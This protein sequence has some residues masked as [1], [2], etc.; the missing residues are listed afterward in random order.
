[1][2]ETASGKPPRIRTSSSQPMFGTRSTTRRNGRSSGAWAAQAVV[3]W[4]KSTWGGRTQLMR[5]MRSP[6]SAPVS[7]GSG[8]RTRDR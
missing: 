2:T 1:M 7:G 5:L 8:L 3:S 6:T 4:W